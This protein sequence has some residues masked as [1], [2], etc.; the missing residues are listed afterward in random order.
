MLKIH[1]LP[2]P[3]V[4]NDDPIEGRIMTTPMRLCPKRDGKRTGTANEL[5]KVGT[6]SLD[7]SN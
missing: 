7:K 6:V 1:R 5:R 3:V 4:D 2:A